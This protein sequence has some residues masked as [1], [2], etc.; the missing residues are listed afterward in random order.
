MRCVRSC[1]LQ[2]LFASNS[3]PIRHIDSFC[4]STPLV[5]SNRGASGIDGIVHTALGVALGSG[6]R[7]TLLVGDLAAL[8]DINALA[9][10]RK[11]NAPLIIVVLN[12]QGGGIFAN[13]PIASHSDVFDPYFTTPHEHE[14]GSF[15]DGF[16]L[17]YKL[18][19]SADA[20][21]E[22][23]HAARAAGAGPHVIEAR[24]SIGET[25]AAGLALRRAAALAAAPFANGLAE[26]AE[27]S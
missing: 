23:F 14:F 9:A 19:T 5:L 26:A 4:A 3:L 24:T 11:A 21:R 18:A 10:L 13:L 6:T 12:N 20:F 2:L 15:C 27:V 8:H 17:P 25:H 1:C 16:G 7:C 22:A